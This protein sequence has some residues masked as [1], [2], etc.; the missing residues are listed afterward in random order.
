MGAGGERTGRPLHCHVHHRLRKGGARDGTGQP[1]TVG[2]CSLQTTTHAPMPA[3]PA[4][5]PSAP[6]AARPSW[7]GTFLNHGVGKVVES[8]PR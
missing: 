1:G 5:R 6:S 7:P 8:H 3:I 4:G 2:A